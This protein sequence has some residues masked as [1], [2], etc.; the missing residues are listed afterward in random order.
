MATV[1][2]PSLNGFQRTYLAPPLPVAWP[3]CF[4][5]N[6]GDVEVQDAL[7]ATGLNPAFFVG[8][9]MD[10][11]TRDP[12]KIFNDPGIFVPD[13]P[14]SRIIEKTT[15]VNLKPKELS[16]LVELSPAY[17][18]LFAGRMVA[19]MISDPATFASNP[20]NWVP[21]GGLISE[22]PGLNQTP[23]ALAS[24]EQ[25]VESAVGQIFNGKKISD[26]LAATASQVKDAAVQTG[27]GITDVADSVGNAFSSLF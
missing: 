22:I 19:G 3:C 10:E 17:A 21:A 26:A 18:P 25:A 16:A 7:Q 8:H 1:R 11:I 27:K 14:G 5:R 24:A 15:G 2:N 20:W 23:Q 12:M 4:T 6:S 13:L 9:E